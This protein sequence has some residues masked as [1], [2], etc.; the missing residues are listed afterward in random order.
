MNE[1][2]IFSTD[3]IPVY[4][5]DTGEKIVV[6]RELHEKLGIGQVYATWFERMAEYGFKEGKDFFLKLGE[7]TGGRPKTDHYLTLDMAKH[8]AMIQRTE[9]GMKIRQKLIDLEKNVSTGKIPTL[10]QPPLGSVNMMAK[11]IKD[12]YGQ[13]GV[14][15]KFTAMA[16]SKVYKEKTG[17]DI[18]PPLETGTH[19]YELTEIAKELGIYSKSDKPHSGAVGAIIEKLAIPESEKV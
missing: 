15:P 19:F 17:I 13:A 6:G 3:I 10:K 14:D 9:I 2:K 16:V 4:T 11:I 1:L 12:V 8:I 5:T 18:E 7:S